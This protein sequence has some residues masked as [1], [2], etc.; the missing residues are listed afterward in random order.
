MCRV[1]GEGPPGLQDA[2]KRLSSRAITE[3]IK[4]VLGLSKIREQA[5]ESACDAIARAGAGE[6]E[7]TLNAEAFSIGRL[8]EPASPL[9]ILRES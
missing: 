6:Q 9:P 5:L 4:P 7:C 3:P 1:N 8:R 2:R